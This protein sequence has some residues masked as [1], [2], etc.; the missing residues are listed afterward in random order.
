MLIGAETRPYLTLLDVTYTPN[1]VQI[2][3]VQIHFQPGDIGQRGLLITWVVDRPVTVVADF[4]IATYETR[5]VSSLSSLGDSKNNEIRSTKFYPVEDLIIQ[6][7]VAEVAK[8]VQWRSNAEKAR[9]VYDWVRTNIQYDKQMVG[10]YN[11]VEIIRKQRADSEGIAYTFSTLCRALKVPARVYYGNVVGFPQSHFN[12][13]F[14]EKHCWAEFW[15]GFN[16]QPVDPTLDLFGSLS[17]HPSIHSSFGIWSLDIHSKTGMV[18]PVNRDKRIVVSG[19]GLD[20]S[21]FVGFRLST[22]VFFWLASGSLS[23]GVILFLIWK[24]NMESSIACSHPRPYVFS[25]SSKPPVLS[26]SI[27]THPRPRLRKGI[28]KYFW[29]ALGEKTVSNTCF[30]MRKKY[31][32][33]SMTEAPEVKIRRAAL[34]LVTGTQRIGSLTNVTLEPKSL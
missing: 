1:P 10:I 4:E 7:T 16:W 8:K 15:D 17:I 18:W 19:C 25:Q 20:W 5:Y 2:S 22:S 34:M 32:W 27:H 12:G 33:I 9:A 23:A 11:P 21:E 14:W 3:Q 29:K 26:A 24:K 28:T 6:K 31:R 13:I 30:R